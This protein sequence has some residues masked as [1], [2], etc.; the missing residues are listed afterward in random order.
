MK[1][2]KRGN[3]KII[4][5]GKKPLYTDKVLQE[6]FTCPTTRTIEPEGVAVGSIHLRKTKDKK[7][8]IEMFDSD[9]NMSVF[10]TRPQI[11]AFIEATKAGEHYDA[12]HIDM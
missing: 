7:G 11:I 2:I 10:R 6:E 1:I 3:T 4:I 12:L 5:G 9:T 8:R